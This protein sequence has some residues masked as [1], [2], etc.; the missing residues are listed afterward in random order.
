MDCTRTALEI[1]QKGVTTKNEQKH[2]HTYTHM[3]KD[4]L[5]KI[6]IKVLLKYLKWLGSKCQFSI[7][8]IIVYGH[9]KLP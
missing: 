9:F 6:S 8:P 7:L 3:I 4:S 2:I 1:Y 5:R